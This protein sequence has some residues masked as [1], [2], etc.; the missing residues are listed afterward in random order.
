MVVVGSETARVLRKAARRAERFPDAIVCVTAGWSD[1]FRVTMGRGP[2]CDYLKKLGV[3]GSRILLKDATVFNTNGEMES[4]AQILLRIGC[5]DADL[6][7]RWWH[8]PRA[9]ILLRARLGQTGREQVR[10]KLVPVW[11]SFDPLGMVQEPL[12][13]FKNRTAMRGAF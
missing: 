6:V 12:A 10:I 1:E 8:L 11:V 7:C 3:P 13:W 2:M 4:F 9:W 5:T